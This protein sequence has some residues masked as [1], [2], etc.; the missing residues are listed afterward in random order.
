M[1]HYRWGSLPP[2]P[3][4][5]TLATVTV[6][7]KKWRHERRSFT[8]TDEP[9]RRERLFHD[10]THPLEAFG[11]MEI[12]KKGCLRRQNILASADDAQG[13]KENLSR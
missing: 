11:D 5:G 7:D 2:L 13:A 4:S 6:G 1:S 9:S 3:P 12:V 10:R 8:M